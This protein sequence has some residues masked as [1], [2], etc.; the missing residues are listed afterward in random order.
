MTQK[1]ASLGEPVAR[2]AAPISLD[3]DDLLGELFAS[4]F[5]RRPM[6]VFMR[7]WLEKGILRAIRS[8]D[9]LDACLGLRASGQDSLQRR[10]L[11]RQRNQ[12]LADALDAVALDDRVSRWQRCLR[13]APEVRQFM[14]LTWRRTKSLSAPLDEWPTF[15]K[16]LW[17][18]A[19]T[20]L[21]LPE[22][23]HGLRHAVE[24]ITGYSR[25]ESGAKLLARFM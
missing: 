8:G 11:M 9:S 3:P 20:D 18:A 17:R 14:S 21:T 12:H 10:L 24:Q 16:C 13:L 25:N 2:F 22:T 23:A 1:I 5:Y 4:L 6:G 15:K 7:G 19:C